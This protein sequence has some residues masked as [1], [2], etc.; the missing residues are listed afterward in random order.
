MEDI[1]IEERPSTPVSAKEPDKVVE[2]KIKI[3]VKKQGPGVLSYLADWFNK[4]LIVFLLAAID[5]VLFLKV[6]NLNAFR[7]APWEFVPEVSYILLALFGMSW[8]LM[9]VAS[10]ARFI[11]NLV[12][13]ALVAFLFVVLVNQFALFDSASFLHEF[14]LKWLDGASAGWFASYSLLIAALVILLV[15]WLF[16]TFASN[17]KQ[18]YMVVVLAAIASVSVVKLYNQRNNMADFYEVYADKVITNNKK[19]NNFVFV[20]VPNLPTYRYLEKIS[21]KYPRAKNA[22]NAMLGLYTN[23]GFALF[24]NAYT[25][26]ND[27]FE[28]LAQSLN[29]TTDADLLVNP[30]E[31]ADNWD[32]NSLAEKHSSLK[33]NE[34]LATFEKNGYVRKVFEDANAELC[35]IDG[36]PIANAC[37]RREMVPFALNEDKFSLRQRTMVLL[38][39]WLG[40]MDM[41]TLNRPLY[42]VLKSFNVADVP[43]VGI[44]YA[45]LKSLGSVKTLDTVVEDIAKG[46]GNRAYVVWMN[47]PGQ[48]FVY[49]EFCQLKPV[50]KWIVKGGVEKDESKQMNAYFEQ[51]AC[52]FGKIADFMRQLR[53]AGA[54]KNTV[55]IL[56]GM[57]G[58]EIAGLKPADKFE[59]QN[60]VS[61]AIRDPKHNKFSINNQFCSAPKI[62]R[63]YL[64]KKDE[65]KEQEGLNLDEGVKN[66]LLETIKKQNTIEKSSIDAL[67][68]AN[69]W[70]RNWLRANYP[71]MVI[72][73]EMPVLV[74]E[75]VEASKL[76]DPKY[77]K[78]SLVKQELKTISEVAKQ[79]AEKVKKIKL[80][81]DEI[82]AKAN[83]GSET[84]AQPKNLVDN[85]VAE[86]VS[87]VEKTKNQESMAVVSEVIEAT[88]IQ[89]EQSGADTLKTDSLPQVQNVEI[90]SAKVVSEPPNDKPAEEKQEQIETEDVVTENLAKDDETK[91]E[92]TV[93]QQTDAEEQVQPG[94]TQPQQKDLVEQAKSVVNTPQEEIDDDQ[95]QADE[96]KLKENNPQQTDANEPDSSQKVVI[97]PQGD[98]KSDKIIIKIGT[99]EENNQ[100][101]NQDQVQKSDLDNLTAEII[102]NADEDDIDVSNSVADQLEIKAPVPPLPPVEETPKISQSKPEM[103]IPQLIENQTDFDENKLFEKNDSE[104]PELGDEKKN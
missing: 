54:D 72:P 32:F 1:I 100:P 102:A 69:E 33:S 86:N 22:L 64:F 12:A 58:L 45:K 93:S 30:A 67:A 24:P 80:R 92:L 52:L 62:V 78:E 17:R 46:K 49:D 11:Q 75:E 104:I 56:Q 19:G 23:H 53:E 39:Q 50:E 29:M 34:L 25:L 2:K 26:G 61:M 37:Y 20:A 21:P 81:T 13:A 48:A 16:F 82:A 96:A 31:Y 43:L 42:N 98:D 7:G 57:S 101:Q 79:E 68:D 89:S 83:A 95:A 14:A 94:V 87:E 28:N 35:F 66:E 18:F 41:F 71:D 40:S 84:S 97:V 77:A 63:Q 70:F 10:L 103:L 36:K 47:L 74:E 5:F 65:C 55:V 6:G 59:A 90:G 38:G 76:Q 4:S 91:P 15:A 60:M 8:L 73:I 27:E 44:D 85:S 88:N 51:T 99:D 3:K 9:F